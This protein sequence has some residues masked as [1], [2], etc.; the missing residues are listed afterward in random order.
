MATIIR[1]LPYFQ[2]PTHVTVRGRTVS[3]HRFQ[4]ILWVSVTP[5][6]LRTFDPNTPRFPAVFDPGF[7]HNFL[8]REEHLLQ[9]AGLRPEHLRELGHFKPHG[10]RVP[11][12]AANVWLHRNRS[13]RRDEFED[14]APFCI[15]LDSG[16]GVCSSGMARAPR[17][18]LLGNRGLWCADLQSWIDHR[19]CRVTI[20][21]RRKFWP[22]S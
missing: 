1:D 19:Q 5:K 9:W 16:V 14:S 2:D 11:L 3:I 21:T 20:R 12:R 17:L 18:P 7:T 4:T 8:I 13:D 15:E 10:E 22:F 6:G